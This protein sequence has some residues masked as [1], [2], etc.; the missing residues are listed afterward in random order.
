MVDVPIWTCA[1]RTRSWNFN[2]VDA[3]CYGGDLFPAEQRGVAM[4]L[5]GLVVGMAPAIGPTLSGW[6]LDCGFLTS[7]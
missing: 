1:C 6:I 7:S 2:A 5:G 4:G 3:G